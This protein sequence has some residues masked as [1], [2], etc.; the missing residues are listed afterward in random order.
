[1]QI[2][3]E[4]EGMKSRKAKD[5]EPGFRRGRDGGSRAERVLEERGL[6]RLGMGVLMLMLVLLLSSV[7]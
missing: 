3:L 4:P 2:R 6:E 7:V 1:M 5:A